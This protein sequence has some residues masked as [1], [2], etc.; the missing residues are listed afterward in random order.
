[1]DKIKTYGTAAPVFDVSYSGF[2]NSETSSV[3]GGTPTF[4]FAGKPPTS[5]GPSTTVPLNFGIYAVRPSGLTS[6]NYAITFAGGTYTIDQAL[7]SV[8]PN[9]A[10]KTYGYGDPALTGALSGFLAAD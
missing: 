6:D 4:N 5:Y 1:N 9:A 2:V 10:S 7:A 3:L 8:T